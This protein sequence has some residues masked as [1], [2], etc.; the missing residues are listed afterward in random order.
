MDTA[1]R[2]QNPA[3]P[4]LTHPL[5]GEI[6][7][8]HL[9]EFEAIRATVIQQ[10][11]DADLDLLDRAF[12]YAFQAHHGQRRISG[13]PYIVHTIAVARI[14]ADLNVGDVAVAAAFLHDVVEDTDISVETI[15]R[16]FGD[17][18]ANLVDGVTKIP[19]LKYESVEKKQA[20]NFHKMLL[21]M[22][23]DLRV[24]LIKFA[25][26]LHNMRT[27]GYLP[28]KTQERIAYETLDVYA[29]LAHRLG[30]H[31]IKWELEDLAFKVLE[32]RTY[33]DLAEKVQMKRTERE[34]LA[35]Q[36]TQRIE[37]Q[38][39]AVGIE[40]RVFG[41]AKHLYS[42]YNKISKRGYSFDEILD[43]IAVRIIVP[44]LEDCYHALGIIHSI[45]T[46]IEGKFSDYVATPKT[47]MYQAL[48]TKVFGP[49]GRILEVQIRSEP[50]HRTAEIGIAAHWKYKEGG[51]TREEL[52]RQMEWL[53]SV[54]ES[55]AETTTSQEFLENLKIN[56]FQE[57]IYVFT[58]RGRLITLPRDATPVDF[59]FAVHSDIGLH[60][61]A[62]KVNGQITPLKSSLRSGDVVEIIV[63]PNQRP[64]TDWLQFVRTSRAQSKIKKWLKEQHFDES[65]KL[66]HEILTR[67]LG[68]FHVKKTDKELADIA[69]LFGHN[70]VQ[71]FLAA[72]GSGDVTVQSVLRKILPSEESQGQGWGSILS[73]VIRRVKGNES[74]VRIHGMENV[75]IT[76]G[77]CCQPLPGDRI[78]G[79]ITTGRGVSVHRVDCKNIPRLMQRPERNI[80]VEWDVDKEATFNV[81][82][83]V[84]GKE[85]PRLLNDLTTAMAKEEVN[86]LYLEMRRE[87]AFAVGQLTI[88]VKSLP[89]LTRVVKRM[90]AIKDVIHV[91]RVDEEASPER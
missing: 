43:L 70:D 33:K 89:H 34:Q 85:R 19:E 72:L 58:P 88:E 91:E 16:E 2:Q 59:A 20:E 79:F 7:P 86:I 46:P 77:R 26:R 25:D 41:R 84:I 14:L 28:R 38:L 55:R 82:V 81:R 61:M 18:I 65:V 21:S 64:N 5:Y 32:P 12:R 36:V 54:L 37:Q 42:I 24:I 30:I 53:R 11:P 68:K 6:G 45:Y 29:P 63:S 73:K 10:S 75:A 78:T 15:A 74:G 31:Q 69:L 90:K 83:R 47:N 4:A 8:E 22:S 76:F 17:A 48:H 62:A 67:E 50:M 66:G 56:L 57:E 80:A 27:I 44:R 51:A 35:S 23:Q 13:E 9:G 39:K 1:A 87:D 49:E 52:D 71:S 40:A 60:A 3:L